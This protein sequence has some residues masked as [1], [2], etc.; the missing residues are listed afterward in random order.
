MYRQGAT[1]SAHAL[2]PASDRQLVNGWSAASGSSARGCRS[3][4]CGTVQGGPTNGVG[5]GLNRSGRPRSELLMR[6]G[7]WPD[8][9][10]T[11][12]RCVKFGHSRSRAISAQ[13][14][15]SSGGMVASRESPAR[16]RVVAGW[17]RCR[18]VA[19]GSRSAAGRYA[20]W[21]GGGGLPVTPVHLGMRT[22]QLARCW[23]RDLRVAHCCLE[24]AGQ[25]SGPGARR[26]GPPGN[27]PLSHRS[28][29]GGDR[30]GEGETAGD[31]RRGTRAGP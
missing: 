19:G 6:L 29:I 21:Q 11:G 17:C 30:G 8:G 27:P 25:Y 14:A 4:P 22:R 20:E 1:G 7:L 23:G 15:I 12:R 26:P 9:W 10:S 28:S 16:V 13:L 31:R 24:H 5:P 18:G 3:P 2:Q